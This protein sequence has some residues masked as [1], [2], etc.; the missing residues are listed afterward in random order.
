MPTGGWQGLTQDD[1][2]QAVNICNVMKQFT[3]EGIETRLRF[4]HEVNWYLVRNHHHH[5]A[6]LVPWTDS[7]LLSLSIRLTAPT[8]ALSMT[9][10]LAGPSLLQL[11]V[12][13]PPM[14]RCSLHPTLPTLTNT[15]R[16]VA[17]GHQDFVCSC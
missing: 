10:R 16:Y 8:L 7:C 17:L 5:L 13:S 6:S 15:A 4:A 9:S 14:S 3:D 2:S 12:T 1:N 11:A